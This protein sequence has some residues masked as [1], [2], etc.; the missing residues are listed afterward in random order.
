MSGDP[1]D[2]ASDRHAD[3]TA[4]LSVDY[5]IPCV[6]LFEVAAILLMMLVNRLNWQS[7]F[8]YQIAI[9]VLS[10]IP[11]IFWKIGWTRQLPLT[12][13]SVVISVAALLATVLLGDREVET[14]IAAEISC[15]R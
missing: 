2:P 10:F 7:Y 8:M 12:V 6:V 5:A 15:V 9:T 14:G 4:W 11:L 13:L 3:G 1:G